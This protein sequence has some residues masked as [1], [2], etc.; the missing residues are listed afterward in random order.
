MNFELQK[1]I[2]IMGSVDSYKQ[3]ISWFHMHNVPLAFTFS[4]TIKLNIS[5]HLVM[6]IENRLRWINVVYGDDV[7]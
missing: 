3:Q 6:K 5:K 4:M 1:I 2:A 7:L